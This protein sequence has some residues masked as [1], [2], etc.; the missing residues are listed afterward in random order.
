[1]RS[2]RYVSEKASPT[3]D[4]HKYLAIQHMNTHTHRSSPEIR[5]RQE[6][7]DEESD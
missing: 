3:D 7:V 1:M 5:E 6:M 4:Q 2:S